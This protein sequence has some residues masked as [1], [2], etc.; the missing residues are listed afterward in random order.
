M[1]SMIGMT[2][3]HFNYK[4]PVCGR[5]FHVPYLAGWVYQVQWKYKKYVLC[6]WT[7]YRKMNI[8]LFNNPDGNV[9]DYEKVDEYAKQSKRKRKHGKK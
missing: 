6:S 9:T 3:S 8:I 7:C 5:E 2:D 1:S 4:C